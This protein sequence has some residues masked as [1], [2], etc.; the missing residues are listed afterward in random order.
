MEDGLF[1]YTTANPL[2]NEDFTIKNEA[3]ALLDGKTENDSEEARI[4]GKFLRQLA[5]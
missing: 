3:V 5:R 2:W 1:L 4:V